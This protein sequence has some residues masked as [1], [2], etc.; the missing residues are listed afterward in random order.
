[1]TTPEP[2]ARLAAERDAI[3][4][5]DRQRVL[6]P[7]RLTP[8][9]QLHALVDEGSFLEIGS[10]ARSQ[11]P[12]AAEATPADGLI[13]GW[14]RVAGEEIAVLIE[15]PVALAATDSQVAKNKRDRVLGGAV[16]KRKPV[17]YVLN[18]PEARGPSALPGTGDLFGHLSHQWPQPR[19]HDSCALMI[20]AVLGPA[21]G[22]AIEFVAAADVVCAGPGAPDELGALT[23]ISAQTDAAACAAVRSL[24][25]AGA[26]HHPDQ[27]PDRPL[28]D[29]AG[30]QDLTTTAAGL[31]DGRTIQVFHAR[32][33]LQSGLARL[34]GIPVAYV[35]TGGLETHALTTADLRA[36]RWAAR[37][38]RKLRIP[39]VFLQDCATYDP[40]DAATATFVLQQREII[41][42]LRSSTAPKIA[43]ITGRGRAIGTFVLGGRQLG[44]DYIVALPWASVSVVDPGHF[45][46]DSA[47]EDQGPWLAAGLAV[48]DEVVAPSEL[49]EH[50]GRVLEILM[51]SRDLPPPEAERGHRIVD[52]LAKV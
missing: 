40:S 6:P 39:L 16:A 30:R 43:V 12:E 50:L 21:Q 22:E 52:D 48:I 46:P 24:L 8:R 14:A 11:H 28:D 1:M 31:F 10:L 51:L 36:L 35:G 38:T 2:L 3:E 7:G 37:L 25:A 17:V 15:D 34:H 27:D 20:A 41:D 19:V 45:G 49:R 13:A 23:D 47:P 9:Q 4:R 26:V 42:E 18:G 32:P 33:A 44:T 29:A 5:H